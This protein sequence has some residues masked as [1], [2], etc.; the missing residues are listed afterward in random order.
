MD[1]ACELEIDR[2]TSPMHMLEEKVRGQIGGAEN[3]GS[4]EG[5]LMEG[6]GQEVSITLYRAHFLELPL[7]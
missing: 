3:G 2:S 5:G 6:A 4:G 7:S 1:L